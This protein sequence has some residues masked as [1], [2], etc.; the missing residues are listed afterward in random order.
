MMNPNVP[1]WTHGEFQN[2]KAFFENGILQNKKLTRVM[3]SFGLS[4]TV[5]GAAV[6]IIQVKRLLNGDS[7]TVDF[8]DLSESAGKAALYEPEMWLQDIFIK[9]FQNDDD[10][11]VCQ[12]HW[13]LRK[14]G[15]GSPPVPEYLPLTK[16]EL[17]FHLEEE[18]FM[19]EICTK[20]HELFMTIPGVTENHSNVVDGG[21]TCNLRLTSFNSLSFRFVVETIFN[22]NSIHIRG[23]SVSADVLT[24]ELNRD[25][26]GG[27]P[28]I[29]W[30]IS[31]PPQNSS[32]RKRKGSVVDLPLNIFLRP[33][34]K[35]ARVV[36]SVGAPVLVDYQGGEEELSKKDLAKR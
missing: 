13:Y 10:E 9:N 15:L 1:S 33:K 16:S 7:E 26:Q 22:P 29:L 30:N 3:K 36:P 34:A 25:P 32:K 4:E 12:I 8:K 11:Q 24:L 6:V 28:I 23:V 21:M 14:R 18:P 2:V 19:K 17:D 5:Y 27:Y 20:I 31:P 35:V